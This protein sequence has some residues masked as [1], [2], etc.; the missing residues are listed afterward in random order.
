M[1]RSQVAEPIFAGGREM[2]DLLRKRIEY[3]GKAK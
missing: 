2:V 1:D 3:I